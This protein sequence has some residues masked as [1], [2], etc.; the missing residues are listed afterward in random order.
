MEEL[1]KAHVS[2]VTLGIG[3]DIEPE[4]L[5]KWASKENY[6]IKTDFIDMKENPLPMVTSSICQGKWS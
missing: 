6:F 1:K 3:N 5:R 4:G 2:I